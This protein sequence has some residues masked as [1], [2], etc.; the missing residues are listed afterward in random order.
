LRLVAMR[1]RQ[2]ARD[3]DG[4]MAVALGTSMRSRSLFGEVQHDTE[5]A[6]KP[7]TYESVRRTLDEALAELQLPQDRDDSGAIQLTPKR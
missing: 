6:A 1:I 2:H 7:D 4:G 5:L 3:V